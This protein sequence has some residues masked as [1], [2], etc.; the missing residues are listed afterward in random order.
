MNPL[1]VEANG[2]R[3]ISWK[4]RA[5]KIQERLR[6]PDHHGQW[7][8]DRVRRWGFP[9]IGVTLGARVGDASCGSQARVDS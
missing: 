6:S 9:R 2:E 7:M 8:S 3:P 5:A 4:C 1:R